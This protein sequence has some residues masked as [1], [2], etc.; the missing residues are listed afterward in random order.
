MRH[1]QP[2]YVPVMPYKL[3]PKESS[4]LETATPDT[5]GKTHPCIHQQKIQIANNASS[6]FLA[7]ILN[8][9]I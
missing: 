1:V 3:L 9:G 6:R 8:L 4:V 2:I 5:N 7:Q